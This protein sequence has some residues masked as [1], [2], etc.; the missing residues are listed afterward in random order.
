VD[1]A[2]FPNA[3]TLSRMEWREDGRRLTFEYNQRGHQ[4]YR[5]IEVDAAT[6]SA[7]AIISEEPETFFHYSESG[8]GT[9]STTAEEIVW[10]SERDG[11]NHLYLYDGATGR[12][13]NQITRGEWVVRQVDSVDVDNRQI[14]FQASG[15]NPTR[16]PTS[17]TTT[18]S[19]STGPGWWPTPRPTAPT[20]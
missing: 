17:S 3:Y 16:I 2:L 19:T 10:M 15:M 8:S 11:W 1:D 12:V 5:I 13:K 18:A 20:R 6:G 7:R 4:V 14:W 9:T